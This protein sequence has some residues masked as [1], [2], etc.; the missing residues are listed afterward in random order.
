[1]T[2]ARAELTLDRSNSL[3]DLAARINAE[4]DATVAALNT[5]VIHAMAA[6]DLLIEAKAQV[7]HGHWL[8]WL[9]KNCAIS[10]RTVQLYTKLAKNRAT[11]EKA[12]R[13]PQRGVADLTLNEAAALCVLAGRL[14]RLMEFAKRAETGDSEDL[15]NQCIAEGF[16]VIHDNSYNPFF[17]CDEAGKHD[18]CAFMLF[19]VR[20]W[21]WKLKG[22]AP[23]VEY[24]LQK[25]FKDPAEWLGEEGSKFRSGWGGREPSEKFKSQ[26]TTFLATQADRTTADIDSELKNIATEEDKNRSPFE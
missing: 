13:N 18:W 6:G 15:I 19:L 4:H 14:E 3:A 25:Q 7:A 23:H 1:M 9:A 22:A 16:G 17:H 20:H 26:W 11:I 2:A 21:G 24:L 10:E 8:P 5:S 12:M